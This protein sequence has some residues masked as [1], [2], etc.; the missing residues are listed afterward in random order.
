MF[1]AEELRGEANMSAKHRTDQIDPGSW[2]KFKGCILR[3]M[4]LLL[5]VATLVAC[6]SH[7]SHAQ[8]NQA[9]TRDDTQ[10][11]NDIQIA[12]PVTKQIDF[13]IY[14][15]FRIGRDISQIV[16]RRIGAGFTFKAGKYLTFTPS[17]LNIVMRPFERIKINEN[18]LTFAATVRIPLG[19]FTLFDR[20]QFERRL[21]LINSTRYRNRFQVEHPVK[22][23]EFALQ[24][25]ASDEVFYDWIINKWPRNRF[26][27]GVSRKFNNNFTADVYYMRQNDGRARPGNLHIIGVIY[28]LR[29]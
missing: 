9:N 19:K 17:Y 26:A 13:T 5:C 12:V 27:V 4:I 3:I 10:Q 20:N 15:T 25:F 2:Q 1:K 14:S 6:M 8:V 24:L 23:G 7:T 29:F 16:D 21:R 28:R 18:R 22:I 11:W